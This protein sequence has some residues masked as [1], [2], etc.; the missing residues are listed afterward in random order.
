MGADYELIRKAKKGDL[1]AADAIVKKYY[2][3][4]FN[5]CRY[6]S[7]DTHTAE[8]LTQD[9][10]MSFFGSLEKYHHKGKLLNYL[11]TVAKNK[12]ADEMSKKRHTEVAIEYVADFLPAAEYNMDKAL[13]EELLDEAI[14][15]LPVEQR[16]AIELFYFAEKKQEEIAK[17][18]GI[19]VPLV[20]YRLRKGKKSIRNY[21]EERG[22]SI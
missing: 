8:D 14:R 6:H 7:F 1:E 20:K 18:C 5:Y 9:T 10:F 22:F 2:S 17:I 15:S 3:D 13:E 4:I 16:E 21:M 11:Y 19:G 12:C